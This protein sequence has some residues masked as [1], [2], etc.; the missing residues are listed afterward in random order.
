M[1]TVLDNKQSFFQKHGYAGPFS[2]T[3]TETV[4]SLNHAI[5]VYEQ[6]PKHKNTRF[7]ILSRNY[8]ERMAHVHSR[9]IFEAA[10]EPDI[11]NSVASYLGPDILIWIA[12]VVQRY[13]NS[14]GQEWHIDQINWEV[15]GVHVSIALS[16][17]NLSNG[18]LQVIPKT[19]GY[20]LSQTDLRQ[21][22]SLFNIDRWDGEGMVA[23]ADKLHPENA[24]HQLVNLEMVSGQYAFTK[25]GLWH[26]ATPNGSSTVRR[27]LVARYMRPDVLPRKLPCVLVRGTDQYQPQTLRTAPRSWGK[28]NLLWNY[29]LNKLLSKFQK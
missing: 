10:T 16:D 11:M 20:H 23:L 7:P 6:N 25:G 15:K 13:P 22:M 1:T 26:C 21:Q 27:A 2:L 24:P 12:Q 18:C 19:H 28:R 3:A 8:G 4:N 5:N 17:M 14:R 9:L 29:R